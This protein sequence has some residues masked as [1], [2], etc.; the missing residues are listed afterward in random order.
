MN[1]WSEFADSMQCDVPLG[2]Q[3]WFRL[4]GP[5]KYLCRPRD[6]HELSE[7]VRRVRSEALPLKVLGQGANVLIDDDGFEGVVLRLDQ[8]AFKSIQREGTNFQVG[9]GVDLMPFSRH[10]SETGLSGLEG[11]AGIPASVGGAV[12]MNAGGRFGDFGDVVESVEV[13]CA[14]GTFEQWDRA[15]L[16]FSYRESAVEDEI[17][18]SARLKMQ[19]SDPVQ[20]GARFAEYWQL[21]RE[22]QPIVECSAGC[23]FKNP[24]GKSA[25]ALI[26]RA[27]LKG[28]RMGGARVSERHA[29]F[30]VADSGAKS[31]DV[32][33]LIDLIRERV[34]TE[35]ATELQ[36]EVDI[37]GTGRKT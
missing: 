22:S 5:A 3:T 14:D 20:T 24:P 4:G 8:P 21:K 10:C 18:T 26:D 16:A 6:S 25:G 13:V 11:M 23:I 32:L 36:T 35:F 17:V 28:T 7:L 19:E 9:A 33:H 1:W 2:R 29:N 31:A 12:R 27:G 15:Q 37:W 34:V 30:I